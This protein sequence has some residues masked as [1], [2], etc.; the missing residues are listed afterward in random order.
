[1]YNVDGVS[2]EV[3]VSMD[4]HSSPKVP[5]TSA[6]YHMPFRQLLLLD[7]MSHLSV[8]F[9]SLELARVLSKFIN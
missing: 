9:V 7:G 8:W 5:L 2:D 6:R 3:G 4:T 1:M